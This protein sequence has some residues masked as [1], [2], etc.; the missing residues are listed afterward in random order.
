M[1]SSFQH[2]RGDGSVA[3]RL[4]PWDQLALGFVTA[5]LTTLRAASAEVATA[6][7]EQ[8]ES[9]ARANNVHYLFGRVPANAYHLRHAL[10]EQG[11]AMV[12]CSLTLSRD[13]FAGL[14]SV[15]TR[16]RPQ[17]RPACRDDL[18][19]LQAIA[20]Q[21]FNHGRFLEDPAIAREQAVRRTANW[22]G[23][24]FDQ[25]LLQTAE[26]SGRIVGFHA[27]R[28]TS[29]GRHADL[30]LTG[31][32]SRY[33][34]LA[35]PLWISALEQLAKRR[36]ESCA[37][38]VSAANTGIVNLYAKLGFRYDSTLFGYRKFL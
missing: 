22:V 17:L 3:A 13:G 8:A 24:L 36:I 9:W 18:P 4:T 11:H 7:L 14:P 38:L 29:D 33:A 37:T 19:A 16:M 27:E 21:D 26:S 10:S 31:T 12:E 32:A 34:M 35:V 23:D 25:G 15:P 2:Q 30:I 5:E 6:L 20:N 28:I 1:N